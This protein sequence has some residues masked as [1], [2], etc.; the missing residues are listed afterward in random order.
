MASSNSSPAEK[1]CA[2]AY[3]AFLAGI[4]SW[5]VDCIQHVWDEI[6]QNCCLV[7]IMITIMTIIMIM[8]MGWG[9]VSELWPERGLLFAPQMMMYE[10]G[11]LWCND[12][13]REKTPWFVYHSTLWQSY[14]QCHLIGNQGGHGE[15]D[16]EFSLWSTFFTLRSYFTH[17]V[18]SCV[19]G[20]TGLLPLR[21]KVWHV[22][23]SPFKIHSLGRVWTR[24]L[25]VQW[26][27]L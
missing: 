26:Q 20:P 23:L 18:K 2:C 17:A 8:L 22:F 10:H 14:H 11:E 15:V 25:W 4:F 12:V 27:T 9:Y 3:I 21:R 1:S 16:D 7:M 24:E 19:M 13:D 5:Y 6:L